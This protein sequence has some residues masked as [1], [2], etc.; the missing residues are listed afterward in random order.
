MAAIVALKDVKRI[1]KAREL[2]QKE[3]TFMY[4]YINGNLRNFAACGSDAN[5][6]L[7]HLKSADSKK[8]RDLMLARRGI[9]VRDCSTFNGMGS[10]Y[11]R[12]AVKLHDQNLLLLNALQSL[13]S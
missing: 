10:R 1:A 9:L 4:Y 2:V 12:V 7:I 5:Y 13:D 3:R 6:Y 8:V 11:I